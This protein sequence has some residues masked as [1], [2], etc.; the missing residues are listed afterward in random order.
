MLFVFLFVPH[1]KKKCIVR[2]L[3]NILSTKTHL[4]TVLLLCI[5]IIPVKILGIFCSLLWLSLLPCLLRTYIYVLCE[6]TQRPRTLLYVIR[7]MK[8]PKVWLFMLPWTIELWSLRKVSGCWVYLALLG[9][10]LIMNGL[11]YQNKNST[12]K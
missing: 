1:V 4:F 8:S 6:V 9:K 7:Q 2:K 3:K 11:H 12:F 5:I 10:R